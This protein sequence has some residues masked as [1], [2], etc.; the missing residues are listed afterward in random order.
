MEFLHTLLDNSTFPVF[1]AF[2]L[3]LMMTISPCPFCSN[4]TAIGFIGKDVKNKRTVLLNGLLYTL[5]K[6][7]A[8]WL[9]SLVFLL[10][11]NVLNVQH[12]FEKYGEPIL[13]PFLILCG[14]FMLGVFQFHHHD[15]DHEHRS[16]MDRIVE[17]SE[18][19]SWKWAFILGVVFS[20]AFCPYSAVLYFGMLIP[21][22]I[23]EPAGFLLPVVFGIG[24]GLPVIII[25][26]ILA[27]SVAGIGK[28][29]NKVQVIE[30]WFRRIC[31]LLFIGMGIYLCVE[32]FSDHHSHNHDLEHNHVHTEDCQH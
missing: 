16:W 14:I 26:W 25:A 28:I 22:A 2:I 8:Y 13:G 24:T 3:G 31:A 11:A 18:A 9:L 5:G 10:G 12:F 15:H 27:Y 32:I 29:T 7:V 19:G 23:A 4:I 30:I 1:T 20:L 6:V 17:K 21:L